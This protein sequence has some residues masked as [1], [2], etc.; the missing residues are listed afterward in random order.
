MYVEGEVVRVCAVQGKGYR[1]QG[2]GYR[3]QVTLSPPLHNTLP[4]LHTLPPL[5]IVALQTARCPLRSTEP[6]AHPPSHL[7]S[8][9]EGEGV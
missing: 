8:V 5:S 3:A 1:G 6:V 4:V 9:C 2:T 7:A